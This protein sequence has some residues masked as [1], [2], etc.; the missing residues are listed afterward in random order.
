MTSLKPRMIDLRWL[1]LALVLLSVLATLC[2]S[3]VVAYKVQRDALIHHTLEANGAYAA[4]V[5][6]SIGEFLNAAHSHLHY[7]A[8][9]LSRKWGD[10]KAFHEEAERLQAQ[11]SDFN[12][13]A[14][15]DSQG[16]VLEAYPDTLQ[17]VG[18][19]LRSEGI[20][21]AMK[22][23]RPN[24]SDAYVSVAGNL[25]VFISQPVFSPTED[26]LG[27]IGGSVYLRKLSALHTV[28]SSH[29]YHEGTFAF[30][31]DRNRRLLYHPEQNRIGE[32]LGWSK[33]VDAALEGEGGTM[34]VL[35][36]LGIPM[37]AGYAPVQGAGWAVVA[38]QPREISLAPLGQLMRSMVL[39]MIPAGIIG[40]VFIW[41]GA[42]FIA[43]PL[44]R[45][46]QAAT[47]LGLPETIDQLQRIDTRYL[48]ASSLRQAMLTS[49]QLVQQRLGRLMQEAQSDA[50][51]GLANRRAMKDTLTLL[52]QTGQSYAVLALD[53]DH[54]K[55]VNDQFGH[56]AGDQA[57]VAVA[58]VLLQNSRTGDLAC[59]VGG[60][61]F[62]LILPDT[63]LETAGTIGERIRESVSET[64][65]PVVGKLT[66]SI[67]VA[68]SKQSD[69]SVDDILKRADERLY[70]AK[71][72]GRNQVFLGD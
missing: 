71:S 56:D 67:G 64:E 16:K 21:R 70:L 23:R 20:Q 29:F 2:N 53:I 49:A 37:L 65:I 27:V 58:K 5:A 69:R 46:S 38:Q 24:V 45:L 42:R 35:N 54:F 1:I 61:E 7:S 66:L 22:E 8:S 31:A 68:C 34:E 12:S 43:Q 3:L 63:T 44:H 33:T 17:I 59:R 57:L 6:S 41:F 52:S 30:V 32:I 48:E 13:I 25:V 19:T 39:D 14:I 10:S 51:T 72:N 36:Y 15:V 50:L 11:D 4:K 62:T 28:I 40:L 18:S 9:V 47:Q 60:E 26:F 55:R